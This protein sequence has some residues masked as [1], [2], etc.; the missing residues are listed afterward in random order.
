MIS[1]NI[2]YKNKEFRYVYVCMAGGIISKPICFMFLVRTTL[3]RT[4]IN[5]VYRFYNEPSPVYDKKVIKK[6]GVI[7][8]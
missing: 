8:T 2:L 5:M 7:D 3:K 4:P 6:T 1:I